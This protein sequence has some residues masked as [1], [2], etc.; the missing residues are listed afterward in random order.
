[1]DDGWRIEAKSEFTF[2]GCSERKIR[3][4]RTKVPQ[5]FSG[6][7]GIFREV[8]LEFISFFIS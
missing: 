5:T 3:C 1:M 4:K 2:C 7:W 6:Q 8:V